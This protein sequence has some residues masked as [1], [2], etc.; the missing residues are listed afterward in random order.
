MPHAVLSENWSD[1]DDKKK[2]KEDRLFFACE[3]T[4]EVNYLV[5]KLKN[6]FRSKTESDIRSAIAACCNEVRAPRPRDKFVECVTR[7]LSS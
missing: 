5:N 7:R 6:H 1:Y 2:K 3:E 4:W